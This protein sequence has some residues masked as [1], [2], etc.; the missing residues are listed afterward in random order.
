MLKCLLC[1][2]D[3]NG[4]TVESLFKESLF[5]H[6]FT[7]ENDIL[8]NYLASLTRKDANIP[9]FVVIVNEPYRLI[10]SIINICCTSFYFNTTSKML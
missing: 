1:T 3:I 5:K 8:M 2:F 9:E 6:E 7:D 10:E 4:T